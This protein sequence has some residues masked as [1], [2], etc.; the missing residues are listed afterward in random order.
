MILTYYNLYRLCTIC[1]IDLIIYNKKLV[2]SRCKKEREREREN[3]T[4]N[5][6]H[7]HIREMFR[8]FNRIAF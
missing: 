6:M 1:F 3:K 7:R 5:H 2:S 8:I 4:Y